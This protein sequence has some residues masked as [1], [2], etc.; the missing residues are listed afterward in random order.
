MIVNG[1][2]DDRHERVWV[3]DHVRAALAPTTGAVQGFVH[4]ST[5]AAV[6]AAKAR[7]DLHVATSAAH[8][9]AA[10]ITAD[11][12]V[13]IGRANQLV[14]ARSAFA[15]VGAQMAR[16]FALPTFDFLP[17]FNILPR[18][19][20]LGSIRGSLQPRRTQLVG[21]PSAPDEI[22]DILDRLAEQRVL[23]RLRGLTRRASRTFWDV[24]DAIRV[25]AQQAVQR[26]VGPVDPIP[27]QYLSNQGSGP[28]LSVHEISPH[29]QVE[30]SIGHLQI[31]APGSATSHVALSR[32]PERSYPCSSPPLR[33]T[34][35]RAQNL[36]SGSVLCCRRS[37]HALR[38]PITTPSVSSA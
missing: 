19:D 5:M 9:L 29:Q 34:L 32:H 4:T 25:R 15:D 23:P 6:S 21:H 7:H 20:F 30:R 10:T 1:L 16:Q 13:A 17:K 35:P 22:L 37:L 14:T 8:R 18:F 3:S 27:L 28:R 36:R 24:Y 38:F 12:S 11:A 31:R 33:N 26:H 2:G